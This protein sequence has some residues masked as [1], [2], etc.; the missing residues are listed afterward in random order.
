[1]LER[2]ALPGLAGAELDF[3]P[4][5]GAAQVIEPDSGGERAA[6][7]CTLIGTAKLNGLDPSF[8]LRSM[9]AHR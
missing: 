5:W 1:M 7:F 3:E 9:F 6:S 4:S 8:Y 2:Q